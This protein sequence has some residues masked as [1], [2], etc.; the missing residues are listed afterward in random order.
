MLPFAQ[1]TYWGSAAY[2]AAYILWELLW[3]QHGFLLGVIYLVWKI[4]QQWRGGGMSAAMTHLKD[5]LR[6]IVDVALPTCQVL[7]VAFLL[8]MFVWVPYKRARDVETSHAEQITKLEIEKVKLEIEKDKEIHRLKD[9]NEGK[10]QS[11]QRNSDELSKDTKAEARE[12]A[13]VMSG[14]NAKVEEQNVL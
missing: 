5:L 2:E 12:A 7:L 1:N 11:F 14:L 10:M 3:D 13:R 4:V 9:D 8:L 6:R